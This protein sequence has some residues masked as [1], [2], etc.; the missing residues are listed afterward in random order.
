MRRVE[1]WGFVLQLSHY[2]CI[3]KKMI[4]TELQIPQCSTI[5][6]HFK[7]LCS[8]LTDSVFMQASKCFLTRNDVRN[9]IHER[10]WVWEYSGSPWVRR[11][12]R[13]RIYSWAS[14]FVVLWLKKKINCNTLEIKNLRLFCHMLIN[15]GRSHSKQHANY[16]RRSSNSKL[17]TVDGASLAASALTQSPQQPTSGLASVRLTMCSSHKNVGVQAAVQVA[18]LLF[19]CTATN[20][21]CRRSTPPA[22][23]RKL[24]TI[25]S[26]F[27]FDCRR[28]R[29]TSDAALRKESSKWLWVI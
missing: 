9:F 14:I 18:G 22:H 29:Q 4:G 3:G 7:F 2:D 5:L 17:W 26:D 16:K 25:Q 11:L 12:I 23:S 10:S 6:C 8:Q 1:I 24:K 19:C 21:K 27:R 20:R 13:N 15:D 28:W